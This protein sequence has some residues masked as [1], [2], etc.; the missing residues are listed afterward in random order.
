MAAVVVWPRHL[1]RLCVYTCSTSSSRGE[2]WAWFDKLSDPQLLG[3]R[4]GCLRQ[5]CWGD[6]SIRRYGTAPETWFALDALPRRLR[7]EVHSKQTEQGNPWL[8]H[9]HF[10]K[11]NSYLTRGRCGLASRVSNPT[12]TILYR[13]G[14]KPTSLSLS[15]GHK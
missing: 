10:W 11:E 1:L 4:E 8:E 6:A 3:R 13:R 15:D 12:N 5:P 14:Q 9:L 2:R 7:L